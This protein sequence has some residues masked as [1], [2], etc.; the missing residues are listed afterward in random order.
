MYKSKL[1]ILFPG[2][3]Y[4]CDKPLLYYSGKLAAVCGYELKPVPYGNFEPGIKG[5]P[6]KMEEAF[7][8]AL[9]QAEGILR[10]V[11]FAD[12]E[13]LF[14][15]KS[16]GTAVAAAYAE[17]HGLRVKSVSF[18][19]VEQTFRFAKGDGIMFHGTADPWARDSKKIQEGCGSRRPAWRRGWSCRCPADRRA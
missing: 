18:T 14:L 9:Q 5:N 12:R 16:I 11:D 4:T 6:Q 10:D 17:Q 2:I 8:S 15:S 3:G 13:L 1:A 19:P 7:R